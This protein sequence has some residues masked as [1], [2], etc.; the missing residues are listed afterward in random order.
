MKIAIPIWKSGDGLRY[1]IN[2]AYIDYLKKAGYM[3]M[4]IMPEN[5]DEINQ[6]GGL[7]LPGGTDIDP[8]YY[9]D[10]NIGSYGTDP[11]KDEFERQLLFAFIEAGKPIFGI[12]RGFQ[13]IAREFMLSHPK[14]EK[15]ITF[16]QHVNDHNGPASYKV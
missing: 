4:M 7:L 5:F 9:S 2:V 8:I 16:F 11:E 6:C 15:F 1:N 14:S 13:L 3:P 10:E 12:C